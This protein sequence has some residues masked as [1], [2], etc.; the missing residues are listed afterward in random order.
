MSDRVSRRYFNIS[1]LTKRTGHSY[2]KMTIQ[3]LWTH[4]DKGKPAVCQWQSQ[5]RGTEG[6]LEIIYENMKTV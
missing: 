5:R 4:S 3:I 2:R 6:N 1:Y